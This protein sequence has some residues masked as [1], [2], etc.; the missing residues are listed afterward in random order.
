M[1]EKLNPRVDLAFKKIFGVEENK[2]LTISLINSIV[3]P[4]DQVKSLTLLNPYNPKNFAKDKVSILDIKA[5]G[6]DGKRFNIEIQ[7]TDE[8]DYDKRALYYWGKLYTEQLQAGEK[9]KTLSKAIGIHV[10]NFTSIP[11]VKKY[12]NVFHIK[13]KT[14]NFHF[15]KDLELHTIELSKFE[16]QVQDTAKEGSDVLVG[17]VKTQ[18]DLWSSFLTYHDLLSPQHLPSSLNKPEMKKALTVLKQMQFSDEERDAYEGKLKW[19]R[20]EASALDK[21]YDEGK[22]EGLAEGR[23]EGLIK[24]ERKERKKMIQ[25][26]RKNGFSDEKIAQMTGLSLEEVSAS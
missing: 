1:S 22:V 17:K 24:G 20:I 13:E 11:K 7:I 16:Q 18:L 10:L 3:G 23:V 14:E 5:K 4:Q 6:H 21:K 25:A 26:L 9:Y 8:A 15:F 12:H 19:F 2:D